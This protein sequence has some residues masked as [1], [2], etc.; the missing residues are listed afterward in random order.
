M[1]DVCCVKKEIF[2]QPK[3]LFNVQLLKMVRLLRRLDVEFNH[4]LAF[5][6]W[7]RYHCLRKI[8]NEF[9][10]KIKRKDV[11]SSQRGVVKRNLAKSLG[12]K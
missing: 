5:S 2:L 3:M 6:V 11:A 1:D 10:F 4:M 9:L 12:F 7:I 8:I